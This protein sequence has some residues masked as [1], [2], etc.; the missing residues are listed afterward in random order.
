M[1]R[2]DVQLLL[3]LLGVL[4][5]VASWQFVYN[6]N[7]EKTEQVRAESAVLQEEVTMLEGLDAKR[8]EYILATENMKTECDRVTSLFPAGL[9]TEDEIMYFN[10]MEA[11]AMNQIV[12]PTI[13]MGLPNAVPYEGELVVDDY[14][15]QDEGIK[16]YAAQTNLSFTTTY[17]GLKNTIGYIY[18]MPGRKS[19]STINL[20]AAADGYLTGAMSVDFYYMAGTATEYKPVDIPAVITGKDNIF[21]V[22]EEN[23][24][25]AADAE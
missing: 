13:S 7:V 5:A 4:A 21:G 12:V 11:A 15:L 3:A 9:L 23:A 6:K 10:N 25:G 1:N 17:T 20:S 18:Q 2:K 22:L 24:E 8:D 16:L 14:Q 19:V